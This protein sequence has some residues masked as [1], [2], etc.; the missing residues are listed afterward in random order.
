MLNT[1]EA[2]KF[3]GLKES[4]LRNWRCE[5]KGPAFYTI[6]PRRILYEEADLEAYKSER[7]CEPSASGSPSQARSP[8]RSF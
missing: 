2:A 3:L 8:R 5:G 4:A 1:K 6:S 7:R